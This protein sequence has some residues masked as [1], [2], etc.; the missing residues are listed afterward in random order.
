MSIILTLLALVVIWMIWHTRN[1]KALG[2]AQQAPEQRPCYRGI[3][4]YDSDWEV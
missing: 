1:E 2:R 4:R 3:A